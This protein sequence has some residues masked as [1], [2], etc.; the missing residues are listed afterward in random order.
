[1]GNHFHLVV[2]TP[3]SNLV[4]GM[5][6]AGLT[7][8]C[9]AAMGLNGVACRVMVWPFGVANVVPMLSNKP[10]ALYQIDETARNPPG[11]RVDD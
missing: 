10:L 4:A 11:L 7:S 3:R 5:K 2:E 8:S 9:T 6:S 1:M